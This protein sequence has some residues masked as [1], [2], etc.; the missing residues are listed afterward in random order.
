MTESSRRTILLFTRA[1]E[2]EARAKHLPVREGARL[3]AGFIWSW[4]QR[5]DDAGAELL[6]VTPPSS[7]VALAR[8]LPKASVAIQD[9]ESF[10]ARVESA[11]ALAFARGTHA[12][13]MVGGDGPALDV[14]EVRAAFAHLEC[15]DR[16]VVLAPAVDGGVNAI[17]FNALAE[18]PLTT[19]AWLS[20][21]V[22]RQL[23]AEG[24]RLGLALFCTAAGADLDHP[25]N[26]A[27]LY[28]LSRMPSGWRAFR[29]LL[30]SILKA[31][32]STSS[33]VIGA[34][35]RLIQNAHTTRGPPLSSLA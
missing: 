33:V 7:G 17:G 6:V 18:R 8:L 3:F 4:Q 19:I 13:L 24:H 28:R 23:K 26:V 11:F 16:A 2:A 30:L 27:V 20:S 34:L 35:G 14:S 29:W 12:V 15:H 32:R 10:G 22:Y 5:A 9:G 31:C 25:A 1:P 21:D